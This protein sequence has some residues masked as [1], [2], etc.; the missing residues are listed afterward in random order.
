MRHFA[1]TCGAPLVVHAIALILPAAPAALAKEPAVLRR[2]P[3]TSP[4]SD[5][6]A[7]RVVAYGWQLIKAF[8]NSSYSHKPHI[9]VA[10]HVCEV[11]CSGFVSNVFAE[12][13]PRHVAAIQ[14]LKKRSRPLAEDFY[15][16]FAAARKSPLSGWRHAP[17]AEARP[18][19]VLAWWK[20]EH[21][22]GE[23]T[24]HVMLLA[25]A[26]V[27]ESPGKW[28]LRILDSTKRPHG[29]ETRP[30]GKTGLG[31][32]TIWLDVDRSGEILSY[33]WKSANGKLNAHP[34]AIGRAIPF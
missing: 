22:K 12:L 8:P 25:E 9:D 30:A 31:A 13:S 7:N 4:A 24:G 3:A 11:D 20:E 17:V 18:G 23:D 27:L 16:S 15:T 2:P 19:D 32:G 1:P 29:D 33:H 26:P 6:L 5:P 34:A 10:E 21:E 28:R 14:T